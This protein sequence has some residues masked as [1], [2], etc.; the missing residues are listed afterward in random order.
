VCSYRAQKKRTATEN[1]RYSKTLAD[2]QVR[3]ALS[4]EYVATMF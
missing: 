3:P 1:E 4:L 2:L